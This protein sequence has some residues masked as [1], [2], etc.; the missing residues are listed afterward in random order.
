MLTSRAR[1]PQTHSFR[2]HSSIMKLFVMI[3]LVVACEVGIVSGD[4]DADPSELEDI[5]NE[6]L[7]S[8]TTL[9]NCVCFSKMN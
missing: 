7:K 1:P 4:A 8:D 5:L 3:V 9:G 2:S 6:V